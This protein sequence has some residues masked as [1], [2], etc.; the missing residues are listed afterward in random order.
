MNRDL[1]IEFISNMRNGEV[2]QL[3]DKD[4]KDIVVSKEDGFYVVELWSERKVKK[5]TADI[6]L[7]GVFIELDR[8]DFKCEDCHVSYIVSVKTIEF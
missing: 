3:Y 1:L 7:M 6:N 2:A 5:E 4:N 8:L